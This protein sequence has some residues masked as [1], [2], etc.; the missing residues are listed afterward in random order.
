MKK[1]SMP[2]ISLAALAA[3]RPD[4]ILG[5]VRNEGTG[6]P[7]TLLK[8][9]EQ[10]LDTLNGEVKQTA[11]NALNEAKRAGEVSAETKAAADKLLS[12]QTATMKVVNELKEMLEG[13]DTKVLDV[14][15]Q[16]AEGNKGGGAKPMT[17]GQAIVQNER[18]KSFT[19]G[20]M[21]I[22]VANAITTAAGSGGGLI[23]H[24]EER[25]PV[26]MPRRRLMVRGLLTPASVG[27]DQVH[28]RR[29]VL[30]TDGTGMVA[31]G[32]PSG[33]SE[34]GW[35]KSVERVKKV[36]THT[37]LSEE[38]LADADQ[39]QSEI[40]GELRYLIDLEEERQI[41]AGDGLGENLT[42]LLPAAPAFAAPAGLPNVNH[43]DRLRL[44]ILQITLE[45]YMATEFLLNPTDWTAI[46][47]LKVGGTDNR[48]I[49]GNPGVQGT[50][51][52]WGKG[53]IESN[54]MSSGEWLAGDFPMAATFYDR[55]QT[56]VIMSTEHDQN[57][58]EDMITV[59]ARKRVALAIKRALA[60]VKGDF[61]FA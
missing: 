36:A 27:S 15:Q 55:N 54:S 21:S 56:E 4:S 40:D 51:V 12:E 7:E 19:G 17:L 2:A 46:E 39:L 38:A 30:R 44:G 25:D 20:T 22:D 11:E 31:E 47:L 33:P 42:G 60:M 5:Q 48:Y 13:L 45:D 24:E 35:E 34:F 29:Q 53:V 26:R 10:K 50:P 59:K 1:L 28:Y 37:N 43:V 16:V 14:S 41:V 61:V 49:Y 32:A 18:V 6:D 23:Y 52:L 57:F 8:T 9:V 3:A 58:I